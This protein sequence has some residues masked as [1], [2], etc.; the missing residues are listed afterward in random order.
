VFIISYSITMCNW[1]C[2]ADAPPTETLAPVEARRCEATT[3]EEPTSE[4][5]NNVAS[6][7]ASQTFT[8]TLTSTIGAIFEVG[9]APIRKTSDKIFSVGSTLA[10]NV[11]DKVPAVS[12]SA[13]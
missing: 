11:A 9:L 10:D 3:Q 1:Y 4:A 7:S 12:R 13:S 5:D 2:F 8:T 6:P